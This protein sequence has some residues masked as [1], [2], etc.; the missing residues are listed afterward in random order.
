MG[1][2]SVLWEEE[3]LAELSDEELVDRFKFGDEDSFRIL[4][5]RHSPRVFNTVCRIVKDRSLAED[6]S[7]EVFVRVYRFLDGFRGKSQFSTWLYRLVVN[8]CFSAQR[9]MAREPR[10]VR[11]YSGPTNGPEMR[12]EVREV[13]DTSFSPGKAL[14]NA[15]LASKIKSAIDSLPRVLRMTFVLREFEDLSYRELAEV[16]GCSQGTVKSRL[17]RSRETLREKLEGYLSEGL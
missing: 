16:L 6:L 9:K 10:T 8:V 3:P 7:Q 4:V 12:S 5:E 2:I 13:A 14:E 17:C 15:E 11:L 1:Q